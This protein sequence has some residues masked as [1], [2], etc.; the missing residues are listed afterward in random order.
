MQLI[1]KQ[2]D[3]KHVKG[4]DNNYEL[5]EIDASTYVD[6]DIKRV[7]YLTDIK[8]QTGAHCHY[9]E[10]E[11]FVMATGSCVA[12]IDRGYGIEEI[13]MSQGQAIYVGNM[14]WHHFKDFG[15]NSMLMA[16][17]STKHNSDRTDYLEDYEVYKQKIKAMGLE[18]ADKQSN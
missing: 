4:R 17:S 3:I 1:F 14:V 8:A 5:Y 10:K 15:P 13:P 18:P 16:V 6:Y 7:Y 2:Y 9:E 11:L 12:I